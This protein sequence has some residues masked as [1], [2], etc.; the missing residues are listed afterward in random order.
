M[1]SS[2]SSYCKIW[3]VPILLQSAQDR[4]HSR[5]PISC[6]AMQGVTDYEP[7]VVH[8]L[9]SLLYRYTSTILQDAEVRI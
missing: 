2:S 4:L 1:L 9:L 5:A 8:Q 3:S 7:R 6:E